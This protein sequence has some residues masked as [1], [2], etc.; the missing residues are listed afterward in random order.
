VSDSEIKDSNQ[1]INDI[2][3]Y[4]WS[5][6]S[7]RLSVSNLTK[8]D[9]LVKLFREIERKLIQDGDEWY[10]QPDFD[11]DKKREKKQLYSDFALHLFRE[12][13]REN[14]TSNPERYYN[15]NSKLPRWEFWAAT[16]RAL[17]L[18]LTQHEFDEEDSSGS[19]LDHEL[20]QVEW[21]D[22]I[23]THKKEDGKV[24]YRL[25]LGDDHP[26]MKLSI[27]KYQRPRRWN[28]GRAIT[29][30]RSLKTGF[31]IPPFFVYK[32]VENNRYDVLD[33]QQRI[34]ALI[35]TK[36]DWEGRVPPQSKACIFVISSGED[37][38]EEDIRKALVLLY[39]RLNTGGVNLKPIEVRIGIHE[40]NSLLGELINLVRD[41]LSTPTEE[42]K[43]GWKGHMASIFTPKRGGK[44]LL[45]TEENYLLP[46]ELDL[47]DTLFRPLIYGTI[48][49]S[50]GGLKY[51]GLTTMSGLDMLLHPTYSEDECKQIVNKL[52]N[53]FNAAYDAFNV[54]GCFLRM[55]KGHDEN[56]GIIWQPSTRVDRTATALQVGAFFTAVKPRARLGPDEIDTLARRWVEFMNSEDEFSQT[57]Y[58]DDRGQPGRQNTGSLWGWQ[59]TWLEA[60]KPSVE[61]LEEQMPEAFQEL[62]E[63]YSREDIQRWL[64]HADLN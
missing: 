51:Q 17:G 45:D 38:D 2:Q 10:I 22:L 59:E 53:A 20:I 58:L 39:Q 8:A 19:V 24:E 34:H 62:N 13:D 5:N 26:A 4:L 48:D 61:H 6:Q 23:E 16:C 31:P 25:N 52:T 40:D 21:E 41:I 42:G 11:F 18:A 46:H 47:L 54:A 55:A 29:F 37:A 14:F 50:I 1:L 64:D 56:G 44:N 27:R 7:E 43:G 12:Q 35:D 3:S 28:S 60:V 57:G 33:G 63:K 32:D 15:N 30:A 36:A 9:G 49:E